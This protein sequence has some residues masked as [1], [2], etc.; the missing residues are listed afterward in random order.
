M[1]IVRLFNPFFLHTQFSRWIFKFKMHKMRMGGSRPV[2]TVVRER[3]DPPLLHPRIH[4]STGKSLPYREFEKSVVYVVRHTNQK[5]KDQQKR[6]LAARAVD[7]EFFS[8]SLHSYQL[9][10]HRPSYVNA[11]LIQ[12]RGLI[13]ERPCSKYFLV[14]MSYDR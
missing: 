13:N 10:T 9:N 14:C 6:L 11:V 8:G 3:S 4:P 1:I 5:K 12:S 7:I 2:P